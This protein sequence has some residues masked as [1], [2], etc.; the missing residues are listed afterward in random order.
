[1]T[2]MKTKTTS[3]TTNYV[4]VVVDD[5]DGDVVDGPKPFS[6]YAKHI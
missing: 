1:M 5:D 6:K 3:M 2:T 4:D